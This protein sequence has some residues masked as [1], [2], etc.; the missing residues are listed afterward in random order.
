M[1]PGELIHKQLGRDV[2]GDWVDW[3]SYSYIPE[4]WR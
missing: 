4:E 2:R 1:M 3:V